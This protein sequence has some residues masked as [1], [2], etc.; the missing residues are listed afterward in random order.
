[1]LVRTP[2]PYPSESLF[3]FMLRVSEANGYHTPRYLWQLIGAKPWRDIS[4]RFPIER[5]AALLGQEQQPLRRIAY[6]DDASSRRGFKILSHPLGD[7]LYNSPLRLKSAAF[8]VDCIT[9]DLHVDAFWDLT[10]A[11]GCDRHNCRVVTRCAK[12]DRQADWRRPGLLVCRCGATYGGSGHPLTVGVKEL[13]SVI[14]AKLHSAPRDALAN[15]S[16][17]PMDHLW[18]MPLRF[19]LQLLETMGNIIGRA[20]EASGMPTESAVIHSADALQDWPHG[21]HRVLSIVGDWLCTKRPR[22]MGM[23]SQFGAFYE[24]MFKN[25]QFSRHSAFLKQE[26]INFGYQVWGKGFIDS[27]MLRTLGSTGPRRYVSLAQAIRQHGI[28]YGVAETLIAEGKLV[29]RRLTAKR[30]TRILVDVNS[31]RLPVRSKGTMDERRAAGHLGVYVSV[32]KE[33]RRRGVFGQTAYG[34]FQGRLHRGEVEMFLQRV[35]S[36][37]PIA[38]SGSGCRLGKIMQMKGLSEKTRADLVETILKGQLTVISHGGAKVSDLLLEEEGALAWINRRLQDDRAGFCTATECWKSTGLVVPTIPIAVRKGLLV[39]TARE[40]RVVVSLASIER[41]NAR[42]VALFRIAKEVHTN[43]QHLLRR[44]RAWR[45]PV[46]TLGSPVHPHE[47][48]IV[49]RSA[50]VID[51]WNR[52]RKGDHAQVQH[53]GGSPRRDPAAGARPES[54]RRRREQES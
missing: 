49:R 7:F 27:R 47:T 4:S 40:G 5:F 9:Q 39:G 31:S 29:I 43:V 38:S 30:G 34:G 19:L 23:G 21:Y 8:C 36:I 24:P 44:C 42:Y 48:H 6:E 46:L 11:V 26:F 53:Y 17:L 32:L 41:F 15:T 35:M 20:R 50:N 13:M 37:A 25:G 28:S 45:I 33:L 16:S 3:G 18:A 52:E 22:A 10:A 2:H 12:C 14:R 1:M 54:A 51:R